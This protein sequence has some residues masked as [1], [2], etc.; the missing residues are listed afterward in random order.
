MLVPLLFIIFGFLGYLTATICLIKVKSNNAINIYLLLVFVLVGTRHLIYGLSF[1]IETKYFDEL[2]IEYN[3]FF[4]LIVP[5]VYLYFREVIFPQK[6]FALKNSIH[7][8]GPVLFYIALNSIKTTDLDNFYYSVLTYSLFSVFLIYVL[9]Y[10]FLCCH[11]VHSEVWSK[12]KKFKIK[13]RLFHHWTKFLV[14]FLILASIRTI[15]SV[16]L[17][18][19]N[20][21]QVSDYNHLWVSAV[22]WI[23]IYFKILIT[24]EILYGFNTL[25]H[26]IKEDKLSSLHFDFWDI[27]SKNDFS[28]IQHSRLKAI[29]KTNMLVYIG[30]IEEKR[31]CHETFRTNPFTISDF[32]RILDIPASHLSYI[33][34][35]HSTISFSD[36]KKSIRIRHAIEFIQSGYL[37]KNT[38]ESLAKKVGFSTYTSFYTSF[39]D[40]TGKSPRMYVEQ[41]NA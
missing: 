17:N 34:K 6:S 31:F 39:K 38:I 27:K 9:T 26:I 4:I 8:I 5:S 41:L 25:H 35:Y 3:R 24:P 7:F 20:E 28:N 16:Y 33:Y 21:K 11:L 15:I 29:V 10:I 2:I 32:A 19:Q 22:F 12:K 1:L 23:P 37:E 30:K 14:L 36:F 40:I 18:T 13:S